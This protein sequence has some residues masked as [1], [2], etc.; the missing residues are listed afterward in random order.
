VLYDPL[1]ADGGAALL[2]A[3]ARVWFAAEPFDVYSQACPWE[4]V[5]VSSSSTIPKSTT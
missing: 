3:D 1:V 5:C 4:A 2:L